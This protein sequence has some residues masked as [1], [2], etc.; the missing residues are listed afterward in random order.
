[1]RKVTDICFENDYHFNCKTVKILGGIHTMEKFTDKHTP[2]EI[3][4]TYPKASDLFKDHMI[5]FCCGGDRPLQETFADRKMNGEEILAMLNKEYAEWK[6][7]GH[8][9]FDWDEVSLS[10]LIDYITDVHHSYVREELPRIAELVQRI[11]HVHGRK[12]PHLQQ[13]NDI[14][15]EFCVEMEEHTNLEDE[16]V[17]PLIKEYEQHPTE[18][19]LQKVVK[20][21][22][23]L[24]DDHDQV[25][26]L[27][28]DMRLVT[29][30]FNPPENVCGTYR[31]TYDRLAELEDKTFH[32]IHLENNVLFKR[33]RNAK[34]S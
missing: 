26:D 16:T 20:A 28:K 13:L 11:N 19:L 1:M 18:E 25:G 22:G 34:V 32:H 10:R 3:V 14:Y 29:D 8:E 30:G 6:K 2:A 33:L 12:H 15:D 21:N 23:G 31:V 5:D 24:E 7:S 27:L 17:F 4:K 9:A